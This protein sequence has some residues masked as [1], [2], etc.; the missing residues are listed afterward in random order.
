MSEL[1]WSDNERSSASGESD[2]DSKRSSVLL[3]LFLYALRCDFA[4]ELSRVGPIS[5][6]V[7]RVRVG[8]GDVERELLGDRERALERDARKRN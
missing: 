3:M 6:E 5:A 2:S 7:D 8:D 1:T 4:R